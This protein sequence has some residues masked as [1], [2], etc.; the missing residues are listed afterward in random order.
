ME[1]VLAGAAAGMMSDTTPHPWDC[2]GPD[3]QNTGCKQ[4]LRIIQA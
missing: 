3:K 2:A 1:H 4:R